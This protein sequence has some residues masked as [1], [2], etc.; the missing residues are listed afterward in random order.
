MAETEIVRE[1]SGGPSTPFAP[2]LF[3][4]ANSFASG[5]ATEEKKES[6]LP[7]IEFVPEDL[8]GCFMMPFD[9]AAFI[10]KCPDLELSEK[11]LKQLCRI[12]AKP[13]AKLSERYPSVPWVI[14]ATTTMGIIVEKVL[15]YY[16]YKSEQAKAKRRELGSASSA[17]GAKQEERA[18]VPVNG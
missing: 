13:M 18:G 9:A 8:E 5:A 17:E 2:S 4:Q 14:C 6:T 7:P 16:I 15:V 10:A 12:W 3:S 1:E 11:E